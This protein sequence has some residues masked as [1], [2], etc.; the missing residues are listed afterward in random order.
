MKHQ[1]DKHRR[2][3]HF[4]VGDQVLV[5]LQPYKQKSVRNQSYS[6]LRRRYYGPFLVTE[7]IGQVAY[8]LQLPDGSRIHPVFHVSLLKAFRKNLAL[9]PQPLP[10]VTWENHPMTDPLAIVRSRTIS[11]EKGT[12]LQ[13]LVQWRGLPLEDASWMSASEFCQA[14]PQFNLEDKIDS[15]RAEEIDRD[16][17]P[18]TVEEVADP[19]PRDS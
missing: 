11:N 13:V 9:H 19:Q 8:R 15:L 10:T 16:L 3:I 7:R 1:A 12:D 6:K 14:F 4:A 2:D 5:K 18:R 17:E